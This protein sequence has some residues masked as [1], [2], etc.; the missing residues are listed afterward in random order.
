MLGESSAD[1]EIA[2]VS[3]ELSVV[4]MNA[5]QP[6]VVSRDSDGR[7]L[8][9]NWAVSVDGQTVNRVGDSDSQGQV[10]TEFAADRVFIGRLIT[11]ARSS[12][13]RLVLQDWATPA[14]A[15]VIPVGSS[16][17]K[18]AGD[19]HQISMTIGGEIL[20]AVRTLEGNLK[21]IRWNGGLQRLGD[22]AEQGEPA[23]RTSI[24]R[25]SSDR[26]M[27]AVRGAEGLLNVS[28][29]RVLPTEETIQK[30]SAT[31]PSAQEPVGQVAIAPLFNGFAV[32]AIQDGDGQLK[33]IT[34]QI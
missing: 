13:G 10:V 24:V 33:L 14:G 11:A 8:V 21:L 27:S 9:T 31:A 28:T 20:T 23:S 22:S 34:W 5:G 7:L 30:L 6:V 19:G 29:W 1:D 2:I 25:M 3:S 18:A 17:P 12:E 4:V 16:N 26:Y 15:D 32:T